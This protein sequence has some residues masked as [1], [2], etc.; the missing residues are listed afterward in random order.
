[1]LSQK[2]KFLPNGVEN[3]NHYSGVFINYLKEQNLW[4]E[5]RLEYLLEMIERAK[6]KEEDKFFSGDS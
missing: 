4:Q 3:V 6:K 1:M 5:D 2:R